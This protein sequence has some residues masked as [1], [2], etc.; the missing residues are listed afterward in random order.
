M[1]ATEKYNHQA[2]FS[3]SFGNGW[4]VF[5][6]QF[7]VLFLVTIIMAVIDAPAKA[8]NINFDPT[9]LFSNIG[10]EHIHFFEAWWA[11]LGALIIVLGLFALAYSLLLVPIFDYGSSMMFVQAARKQRPDFATLVSGFKENYFHIVLANLLTTALVLIGFFALIV[12]GII[13]ACRLV[14]VSYLVMDKKLDPIAAVEESWRMTRHHGWTIFFMAIVS[15]FIAILGLLICLV[16]IF[17]AIVWI[18]G[19]FA[20]LYEAVC[21]EKNQKNQP[22]QPEV[23]TAG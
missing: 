13:I 10:G 16:G 20:C 14:F 6:D 23:N 1:E 8:V 19:S 2:S 5:G 17:P 4:N 9:H 12:P 15:F 22:Q 3:R 11:A 7:L 18:R 21:E